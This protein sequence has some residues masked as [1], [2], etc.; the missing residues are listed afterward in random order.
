MKRFLPLFF[1][2]LLVPTCYAGGPGYGLSVDAEKKLAKGLKLEGGVEV[3]SQNGFSDLERWAFS[4]GLNYRLNSWLKSDVGYTFIDR[5]RTSQLTSK[6]NTISGYWSPRHRICAGLTGQY[7]LGRWKFT[8]RERYQYTYSPLQYVPKYRADGKRL[9]DEQED[10]DYDHLLRSRLHAS[11]N[12]RHSKFEPFAAVELLNDLT[13]SLALDQTR[14]TLG[15]DYK[16][17]KRRVLSLQ[18]QYKDR[19]DKDESDGHLITLGYSF[20]F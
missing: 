17:D 7:G 6:G 13:Q 16:I 2:L 5:Y 11:Y 9:T 20:S 3:R 1:L 8:L 12:I 18:W 19:A 4:L 10:S 15:T 14:F